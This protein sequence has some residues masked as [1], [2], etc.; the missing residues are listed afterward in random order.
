MSEKRIEKY[1]RISFRLPITMYLELVK[2][3]PKREISKVVK[4]CLQCFLKDPG[5]KV[6]RNV[7][8]D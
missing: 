6:R 7:K 2:N 1:P 5:C 4:A 3:T 8:P